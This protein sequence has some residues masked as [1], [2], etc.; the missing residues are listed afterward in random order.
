MRPFIEAVSRDAS[1]SV[2]AV[3]IHVLLALLNIDRDSAV[4][5]FL[6]I[7]EEPRIWGSH[8]V[9]EFLYYATFTH[10]SQLQPLLRKMLAS[11]DEE[12][13]RDASRQI[14]LAAFNHPEAEADLSAVLNGD[15]ICRQSAAQIYAENHL[16]LS[17]RAVCEKHLTALFN[18]P[19]NN[20]RTAAGHW[21]DHLD[22]ATAGGDWNFLRQ[23]VESKAFEEEPGIFLHHLNDLAEVPIDVILHV[24]DRAVELTKKD[25]AVP[26]AKA[27]RFSGYTPPL[28]V[29]LYH[30]TDDESVQIRCLDLLDAMLAF[31]WN[32]VAIEMA[33]A[34]R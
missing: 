32:E 18:D 24:A 2:R 29:R 31:G 9:D 10:Y 27:F 21:V 7:C 25:V 6:S 33:K 26:S 13:R 17:I 30:Q 8:H 5:L 3:T 15:Q 19:E 22:A 14:C 20:V 1:P 16:H 34:E 4:R 28:V 12:A 23:F 11:A